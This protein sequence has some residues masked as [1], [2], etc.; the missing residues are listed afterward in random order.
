MAAGRVRSEAAA[1]E[2][3]SAARWRDGELDASAEAK[4]E[5]GELDASVG[6]EGLGGGKGRCFF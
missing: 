2:M 5:S 1:E 4:S 6:G 3:V